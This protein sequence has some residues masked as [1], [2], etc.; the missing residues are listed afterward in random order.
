MKKEQDSDETLD[1]IG[2]FCPAPVH[3][4]AEKIKEMKSGQILK[5]IADDPDSIHDIPGWCKLRGHKML[6]FK[7]EGGIY[8]FY[9]R[10][11]VKQK[12]L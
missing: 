6:N 2:L 8:K 11:E 4:M 1:A 9:I 5:V 3:L 10:R 12:R 7:S